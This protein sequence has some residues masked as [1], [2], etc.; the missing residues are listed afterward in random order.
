MADRGSFHLGY[1]L[2]PKTGKAGSDRVVMGSSD[3]TK[4]VVLGGFD[5]YFGTMF[6]L[7][8]LFRPDGIAGGFKLIVER[9]KA[10]SATSDAL[11]SAPR[12]G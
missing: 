10:R 1:A 11:S 7:L 3:L 8:V 4:T 2:D 9:R 5:P 6:V 12:S